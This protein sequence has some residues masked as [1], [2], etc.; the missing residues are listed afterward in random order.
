[1]PTKSYTPN[2]EHLITEIDLEDWTGDAGELMRLSTR[3]DPKTQSVSIAIRDV[4]GLTLEKGLAAYQEL[5]RTWCY[6]TT[7]ATGRDRLVMI[8][9]T[10]VDS[11]EW[12]TVIVTF[13]PPGVCLANDFLSAHWAQA[14]GFGRN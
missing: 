3:G 2:D 1:M 6:M 9:A 4:L 10:A 5:T 8:Y 12:H 14:A 13:I 11:N 7:T